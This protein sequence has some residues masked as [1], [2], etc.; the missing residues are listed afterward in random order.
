L[1][2]K[3]SPVRIR[4]WAP[5]SQKSEIAIESNFERELK[6]SLFNFERGETG[7]HRKIRV[8][9]YLQN[10]VIGRLFLLQFAPKNQMRRTGDGKR[11][12]R[13]D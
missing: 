8:A 7:S 6:E 3:R 12:I 13:P 10:G 4:L 1:V 11:E 5:V 2:R 9:N